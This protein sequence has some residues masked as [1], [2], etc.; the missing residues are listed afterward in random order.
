MTDTGRTG[1]P[2]IP[3]PFVPPPT[4]G[5]VTLTGGQR[6][7]AV[8]A[9]LA[10]ATTLVL[11]V[12]AAVLG[13]PRGLGVLVCV[14]AA[15]AAA[16]FGVLRRGV[17]R[18]AG[19]LIAALALAGAALPLTSDGGWHDLLVISTG[20]WLSHAAARVAFRVQVR[21]PAAPRPQRPVLFV[22]PRSGSGAAARVGLADEAAARGIRTIGLTP[23]DDLDALVRT[24]VADGA[25]AVAVA[26]D[27]RAQAVVAGVAAEYALP[28]A[29]IPAGTRN[30]FALDLGVDPQDPVGALDAFVDGGE[31]LVD[32][33]D[34]NGRVFVNTVSMGRYAGRV[35]KERHPDAELRTLLGTLPIVLYPDDRAPELCWTGP[36]GQ[37]LRAAAT[38]LVSN[39]RYR[40]GHGA[41]AGTR[42]RID[43]G[44]LGV[45]VIPARPQDGGATPSPWWLWSATAFDVDSEG[46]V[47]LGVDGETVVLPPPIRFRIRPGVLRARVARRHPGASP[48]ALEPDGVVA[49]L[50][51]L[52]AIAAGRVT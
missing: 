48:S 44:V 30:Q 19:L 10:A 32:L 49:G 18:L 27:D 17:T 39:N 51:A 14:A 2:P 35:R 42:P 38:I 36:D 15:L 34:V 21:L 28:Y 29:C 12:I 8:I 6:L 13:F 37:P 45:A 5:S 16:W 20:V 46:P 43:A 33:G 1:S 31:H 4:A 7:A 52:A 50:R 9:L 41:G 26:G 24:A 22:D 3:P 40:L 11:A 25:D 23:G 47:P